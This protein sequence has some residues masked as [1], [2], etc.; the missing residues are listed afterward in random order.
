MSFDAPATPVTFGKRGVRPAPEAVKTE[1][2]PQFDVRRTAVD[3]PPTDLQRFLGGIPL[4]TF[5]MIVGLIS[6]FALEQIFAFDVGPGAALSQ[7]SL[8]ALGAVSYDLAFGQKEF[9]R[10]LLAPLL[11]ASSSHLIGNCVA[12]AMV[13]FRLEPL[14][15]RGWFALVFVA[16]AFGGVVGSMIGNDPMMV[17]VG[18]SG[19]ITGLVAA[20]LVMSFDV[21]AEVEDGRKLRRRALFLLVPAL[22]PLFLGVR[23]QVDY[24]AHLGGAIVGAAMASALIVTW[25]GDSFRPRWAR[26]A[27]K[28]ALA[29]LAASLLCCIFIAVHYT[30]EAAVAATVMSDSLA[31][32]PID[33]IE[34][35]STQLISRYPSDPRALLV[36]AVF[37]SKHNRGNEAEALLRQVMAA[38]WPARPLAAPLVRERARAVLALV[39]LIERRR[40]EALDLANPICAD[41]KQVQS[42]QMLI[43]AKLCPNSTEQPS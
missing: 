13:G 18:A 43:K 3:G 20:G 41:R 23:G 15:G 29:S 16:S 26:A 7:E 36:R 22:L 5:G 11:H 12:M 14:I 33:N 31:A 40:S 30:D 37:L 19:A 42:R 32:Q 10:V 1:P 2:T 6:I 39:F 8:V 4:L 9:W 21:R 28:I 38:R 35:Q 24:C 27:S 17:T 34:G 25:D